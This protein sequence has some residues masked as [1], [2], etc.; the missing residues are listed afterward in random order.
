MKRPVRLLSPERRYSRGKAGE[1]RTRAEI[2]RAV[3]A[4]HYNQPATALWRTI[5][6]EA[7]LRHVRFAGRVLDLGCGD[8]SLGALVI[9][10]TCTL[11]GVDLSLDDLKLAARAGRYARLVASDAGALPF[12]DASF[13][14]VFSNSVLEHILH[15]DGVLGAISRVLREGGELA[16][17]VP[18]DQFTLLLRRP[19]QLR[20]IGR[21]ERAAAYVQELNARVQ[22]YHYLSPVEWQ[23]RLATVGMQIVQATYYLDQTTLHAWE[24]WHNRSAGVARRLTRK[25]L[26]TREIQ[27]RFHLLGSHPIGLQRL[28]AGVF[29]RLL[30]PAIKRDGGSGA[31]GACLLVRAVKMSTSEG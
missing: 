21:P 8:G 24:A 16:F 19:A 23:D 28:L 18:S 3:L 13:D 22:H 10:A 9:P 31:C 26:S 15:L 17:T 5:E 11:V 30:L 20:A 1:T 2:L 7:V 29:E 14:M 27:R 12:L 4:S 25:Q 6:V